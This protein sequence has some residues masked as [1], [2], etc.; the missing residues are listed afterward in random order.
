MY[1]GLFVL[2]LIGIGFLAYLLKYRSRISR[3]E[4]SIL[5]SKNNETELTLKFET[6]EKHRLKLEQENLLLQQE[7]M[8]KDAIADKIRL[9]SKDKYLNE[10]KGHI[11]DSSSDVKN[12]IKEENMHCMK[13]QYMKMINFYK[14]FC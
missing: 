3:Q 10:I 7:N 12:L 4:K 8:R 9:E 11:K 6:E 2:S 1:F 5:E 13:N 14:S